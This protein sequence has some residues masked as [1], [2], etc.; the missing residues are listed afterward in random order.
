VTGNRY[1]SIL[2]LRWVEPKTSE[3]ADLAVNPAL[4]P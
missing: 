3:A 1:L 2:F 4:P